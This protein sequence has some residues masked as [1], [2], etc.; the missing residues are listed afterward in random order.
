MEVLSRRVLT[1]LGLRNVGYRS[2]IFNDSNLTFAKTGWDSA[3]DFGF[4]GFLS[5]FIGTGI[6]IGSDFKS[7]EWRVACAGMAVLGFYCATIS[8][9]VW[10][11]RLLVLPFALFSFAT[12]LLIFRNPEKMQITQRLFGAVILFSFVTTPLLARPQNPRNLLNA[13]KDRQNFTFS[14]R[15]Q[16][17][18]VYAD[19]EKLSRAARPPTCFLYAGSD[20]WTLAFL[21]LNRI[22]W[23]PTQNPVEKI[24]RTK[25]DSDEDRFLLVVNREIPDALKKLPAREYGDSTALISLTAESH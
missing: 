3:W 14:Q 7:T 19:V 8:W 1:E 17:L 5:L 15:P 12:C 20:S 25:A 24:T 9:M 22:H 10:N 21:Q 23:I 2:D 4:V 13:I 11:N 18:K 6:L 16:L